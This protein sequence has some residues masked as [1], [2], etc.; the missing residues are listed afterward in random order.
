[1]FRDLLILLIVAVISV[2]LTHIFNENKYSDKNKNVI[3]VLCIV[4]YIVTLVL[5]IKFVIHFFDAMNKIW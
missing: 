1:M 5:G 4:L 3:A 2:T